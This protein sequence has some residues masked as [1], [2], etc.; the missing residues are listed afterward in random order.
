MHG[1][2]EIN[3]LACE[4]KRVFY[5]TYQFPIYDDNNFFLYSFK[6]NYTDDKHINDVQSIVRKD[7][8]DIYNSNYTIPIIVV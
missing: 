7:L 6:A 1:R 5:P 8:H 3:R 4:D 2:E